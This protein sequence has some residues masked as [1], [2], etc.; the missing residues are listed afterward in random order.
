MMASKNLKIIYKIQDKLVLNARD[1]ADEQYSFVV[2]KKSPVC[3]GFCWVKVENLS[4]DS[5]LRCRLCRE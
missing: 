4:I 3:V 2:D 5:S 1:F